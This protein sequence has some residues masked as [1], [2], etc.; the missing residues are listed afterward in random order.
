MSKKIGAAFKERDPKPIQEEA[1]F[2]KKR[3]GLYRYQPRAGQE[4]R[5][6]LMPWV[7][8]VVQEVVPDIPLALDTSNIDAIE[9]GLKVIKPTAGPPYDQLHHVPGRNG[10]KR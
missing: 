3:D 1:L 5:P 6:E 4:R 7:V 8:Q 10:M 9:E 2:K